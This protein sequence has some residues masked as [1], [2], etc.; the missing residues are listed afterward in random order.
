MR[1]HMK[2]I[3]H[4]EVLRLSCARPDT[5]PKY[6]L[7]DFHLACTA[8]PGYDRTRQV[9]VSHLAGTP[10]ICKTGPKYALKISEVEMPE[11]VAKF[12]S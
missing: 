9:K 6:A 8:V 5:N 12:S 7:P 4:F 1:V 2:V 11:K 3:C 10:F